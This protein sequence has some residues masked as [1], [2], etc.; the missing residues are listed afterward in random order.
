MHSGVMGRACHPID[1]AIGSGGRSS[2]KKAGESGGFDTLMSLF[3]QMASPE[4]GSV[5]GL[6]PGETPGAF[7]ETGI[8]G[9]TQLMLPDSLARLLG[10]NA[11]F[12]SEPMEG[13]F[14]SEASESML[15]GKADLLAGSDGNDQTLSLRIAPGGEGAFPDSMQIEGE[16]QEMIL[17]MRLRTVEQH[18]NRIL[19]DAELL[20]ATGEEIPVRLKLELAG[21]QA[22]GLSRGDDLLTDVEANSRAG[23]INLPRML[24]ELGVKLLVIENAG[25]VSEQ[26]SRAALTG[27]PALNRD[28]PGL[29]NPWVQLAG[30][31]T[32]QPTGS[33]DPA[34]MMGGDGYGQGADFSDGNPAAFRQFAKNSAG[35]EMSV[36]PSQSGIDN[37][38]SVLT[39]TAEPGMA[40]PQPETT[41]HSTQVG[42]YDLDSKLDQLK[43][44]PGQ[45]IRVQLVPAKLG[46][47]DLSIVSHRGM[48]TVK[49]T[50]DS[51]AAKQAVEKNLFQLESRLTASGIRVDNFQISV[52]QSSKDE[53]FAGHYYSRQQG[54]YDNPHSGDNRRHMFDQ[55]GLNQFNPAAAK[56]DQVMVNCLA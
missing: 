23:K 25:E 34:L 36:I 10:L 22:D 44:N 51:Q 32:V 4:S 47:M 29:K 16:A 33:A 9:D 15:F 18:G 26:S 40:T 52:D 21:V 45:T 11:L 42:F 24:S 14:P 39:S 56:F 13:M 20:T 55:R 1:T 53:Q 35:R 3:P 27:T 19:A 37:G 7:A 12:P 48:V 8:E 46:K 49:L 54:G 38:V 50:L 30:S 41:E 2:A 43:R 28:I 6:I 31:E 17:P 5:P